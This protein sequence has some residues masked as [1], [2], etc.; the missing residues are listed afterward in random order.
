[1]LDA[2]VTMWLHI[3]GPFRQA[4][5]TFAACVNFGFSSS[6]YRAGRHEGR[7]DPEVPM[8]ARRSFSA[9]AVG[10]VA[11]AAFAAV[12]LLPAA[13]AEHLA[14]ATGGGVEITL[15]ATEVRG[16]VQATSAPS[17]VVLAGADDRVRTTA[18]LF[19]AGS[20]DGAAS[21][22]V[23]VQSGRH[24][25]LGWLTDG[26]ANRGGTSALGGLV[27]DVQAP[28]DE[29]L[30]FGPTGDTD[31][32]GPVAFGPFGPSSSTSGAGVSAPVSAPVVVPDD[33]L[34]TFDAQELTI[35]STIPLS[36]VEI[37]VG[38]RGHQAEIDLCA[39]PVV[40]DYG[41]YGKVIGEHNHCGG[42]YV[43]EL[44]VGDVVRVTG[45]EAGYYE[46]AF[47]QDVPK[48]NTPVT[49]LSG[50]DLFL[51]TCHFTGGQMRLAALTPVS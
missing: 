50:A 24:I 23:V 39:G 41:A 40:S 19:A 30:A 38:M 44:A 10:A 1:M 17:A 47:L 33:A 45:Y 25:P 42:A 35:T 21:A 3:L 37:N 20:D 16:R 36:D 29:I 27:A 34:W 8:F 48:K 5:A 9:A 13:A 15:G 18:P 32:D 6:I 4:F 46:V 43:L 51:Q 7:L 14:A 11:A 22:L 49:V 28:A 2:L 31:V 26:A 12:G